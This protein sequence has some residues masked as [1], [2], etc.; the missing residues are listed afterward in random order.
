MVISI[1][2]P[3][4]VKAVYGIYMAI[5]T[6]VWFSSLS[7]VLSHHRIR[8]KIISKGYW[9]DRAMGLVLLLLAIELV[10]SDLQLVDT[11]LLWQLSL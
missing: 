1:E 6:A 9:L 10:V 2:T 8:D 7:L 4:Q 3:T 5:A 11:L